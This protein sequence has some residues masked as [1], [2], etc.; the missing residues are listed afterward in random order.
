MKHCWVIWRNFDVRP[1][2]YLHLCL[3]PGLPQPH[4]KASDSWYYTGESL[5]PAASAHTREGWGTT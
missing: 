5:E 4:T 3:G 1:S 2:G